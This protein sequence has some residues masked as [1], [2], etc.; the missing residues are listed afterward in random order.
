MLQAA[1]IRDIVMERHRLAT[2]LGNHMIENILG[3]HRISTVLINH[4]MAAIVRCLFFDLDI[5]ETPWDK[6]HVWIAG[7]SK[8]TATIHGWEDQC[9]CHVR[10]EMCMSGHHAWLWITGRLGITLWVSW[11]GYHASMWLWSMLREHSEGAMLGNHQKLMIICVLNYD[12]P[13]KEGNV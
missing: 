13:V 4:M 11:N 5:M 9:D 12:I 7:R 8:S 2:M 10:L 6:H 3:Y 1:C